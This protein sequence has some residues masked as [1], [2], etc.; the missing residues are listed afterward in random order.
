MISSYD[1]SWKQEMTWK[2]EPRIVGCQKRTDSDRFL[3]NHVCA[4]LNEDIHGILASTKLT[5]QTNKGTGQL[6]TQSMQDGLKKK[7]E[8]NEQIE[9]LLTEIMACILI[10]AKRPHFQ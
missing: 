1:S 6:Q 3:Q 2:I 10:S 7:M 9:Q 8:R 4:S 5:V